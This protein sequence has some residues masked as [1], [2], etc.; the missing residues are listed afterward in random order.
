MPW[1]NFCVILRLNKA[2]GNCLSIKKIAMKKTGMKKKGIEKKGIEKQDELLVDIRTRIDLIDDQMLVLLSARA[3]CAEEV[4]GIKLQSEPVFYRPEREAQILNRL[5]SAN[6]GPLPDANVTRLFREII[7]CCLSLEQPLSI[8]FLGPSGTYTETAA[9]KQFGQFAKTRACISIDEVFRD[10]ESGDAHYGLVPIENSTEGIVNQTL[11][12][13]INSPLKIC[14]EVELPIRHML[15][16]NQN[17]QGDEISRIV[18]HQQ[19]LA[20]CRHWLDSNWPKVERVAVASNA[21]AAKFAAEQNGVAAIAGET[22]ADRYDLQILA[23]D[24]EDQNDNKTRFLVLGKQE[25]GPSGKDKT[26]ILVSVRNEPGAL[27]RILEPFHRH[28]VSLTRIETR[29]SRSS[30]WSY[31]FFIDFDGHQH[32][33]EITKLL[34]DVGGESRQVKLLGSYPQAIT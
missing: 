27:Y 1:S 6:P 20:Q 22:A 25:V 14:S 24:I 12:C 18:S 28:N 11:D 26:S 19:S 21:E 31:V 23:H 30:D 8:A 5:K 33:V 13:L 7:S 10:V 9:I 4:A 16:A 2:K 34:D 15:M 32:D 29:P 3:Q 17:L